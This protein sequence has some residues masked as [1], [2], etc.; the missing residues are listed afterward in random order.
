MTR[1]TSTP[2]RLEIGSRRITFNT[3]DDFEFNLAG[4][5]EL[6]AIKVAE[7]MLLD[8]EDLRRQAID[9]RRTEKRFAEILTDSLRRANT[10]GDTLGSMDSKLFSQD[11]EWRDII[12]ALKDQPPAYDEFKRVALAKYMQY[13]GSR[14][15]TLK[16][17]YLEKKR[18]QRMVEE[19]PEADGGGDSALKETGI[20]EVTR[21]AG[22]EQTRTAEYER[23]RR[24]ETVK[25]R[26]PASGEI[27]IRLAKHTFRL[28]G[29]PPWKLSD[30]NGAANE[31]SPGM[32]VVGRST[33]NQV[34]V[35]PALR[36]VSRKHVVI[37]PRD[38]GTVLLT[39]VSSHGTSVPRRLLHRP[40]V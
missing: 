31:L 36:D 30:E 20:F 18:E 33:D 21:L 13:L 29:G 14:L 35:D 12:D 7:F 37:E 27:E 39:D 15:D 2:L 34:V 24:G 32:N 9:I 17:I 19:A 3:L 25:L 10:I 16:A 28:T 38:D 22:R 4:R 8:V 1:A 11:H 23:L 5:T 40:A 26:P 6:P